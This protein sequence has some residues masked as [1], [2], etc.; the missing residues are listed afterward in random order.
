MKYIAAILLII[1]NIFNIPL[2]KLYMKVHAWYIPLRQ[3]DPI[4]YYA[5]AP[6]YWIL[7]VLC[8]I[9]GYPCEILGNM[10]H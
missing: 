7:V 1:L 4:L 9:I 2:S 3:K 6:F 5:F 8:F 10:V